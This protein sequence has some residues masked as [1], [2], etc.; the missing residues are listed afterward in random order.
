MYI[1]QFRWLPWQGSNSFIKWYRK[2]GIKCHLEIQWNMLVT[3]CL[4]PC[5]RPLLTKDIWFCGLLEQP[6]HRPPNLYILPT[7][8]CQHWA[9]RYICTLNNLDL[10]LCIFNAA[11]SFFPF[12]E[13]WNATVFLSLQLAFWI[14][15][16]SLEPRANSGWTHYGSGRAGVGSR[17]SPEDEL[18]NRCTKLIHG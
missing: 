2:E 9:E 4:S 11:V 16:L 15:V 3:L 14:T 13:L 5:I 12:M 8:S 6:G 18:Y 17:Y 7:S 10:H 1:F